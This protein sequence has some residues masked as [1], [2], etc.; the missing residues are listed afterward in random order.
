MKV[1]TYDYIW[2]EIIKDNIDELYKKLSED[3]KMQ[4]NMKPLSQLKEDIYTKYKSENARI[5]ELYHFGTNEEKVIDIHK[6]AACFTKVCIEEKVSQYSLKEKVSD[7][8]FL[9]NARLAY[10]IGLGMIRMNLIVSYLNL[11][12]QDIVD[13]LLAT[14]QL[15]VP[16]TNEGHDEYNEG[17]QK[18]LMLNDVFEN[19]F[20][21]LTYSDM[22]FWIELYNR[23]LLEGVLQPKVLP[24]IDWVSDNAT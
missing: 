16:S 4:L 18:T 7:N 14:K 5:K 17:R 22:L 9:F 6:I 20:D 11:N 21:I 23:Q 2:D 19:E 1:E 24:V 10:N 15:R 3:E 8:V 12:K 13:Q